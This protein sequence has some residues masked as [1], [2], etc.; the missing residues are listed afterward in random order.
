M[1]LGDIGSGTGCVS[2]DVCPPSFP[3]DPS[4]NPMPHD[5]QVE[6]FMQVYNEGIIEGIVDRESTLSI[7]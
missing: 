6:G 2:G 4:N 1:E 5:V 7:M 3:I